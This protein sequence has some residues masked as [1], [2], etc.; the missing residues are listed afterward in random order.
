MVR[1]FI[2]VAAATGRA[3][4]LADRLDDLDHV[5]AANVV[6]GD[7]DVIVEADAAE[8]YDIIHSVATR[9]RGLDDV[10]DTKTYVCLE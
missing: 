6:A 8:V 2:M 10:R 1:A 3:E 7:F 9:I 5:V 4:A